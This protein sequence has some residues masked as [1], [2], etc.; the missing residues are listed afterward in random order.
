MRQMKFASE[1]ARRIRRVCA[2][3]RR[4]P[5][6]LGKEFSQGPK[7]PDTDTRLPLN[8]TRI[9]EIADQVCASD[10]HTVAIRPE[11]PSLCVVRLS[12]LSGQEESDH[13]PEEDGIQTRGRKR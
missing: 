1:V 3:M 8:P 6:N 9:R 4:D 5:R 11:A 10:Y 12:T 2:R 7:T 13:G